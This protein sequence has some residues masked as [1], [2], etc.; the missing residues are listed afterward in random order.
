MLSCMNAT[1]LVEKK[2]LF[3]LSWKESMQLKAHTAMCKI[4]KEYKK[5][6][7]IIDLALKNHFMSDN[8]I[9][10]NNEKLKLKT[11]SKLE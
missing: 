3:G 8:V 1:E 9:P 10:I 7:E 4:C 11:I 2:N 6:S 5:Q